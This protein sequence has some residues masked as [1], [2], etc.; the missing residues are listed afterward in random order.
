VGDD[1]EFFAAVTVYFTLPIPLDCEKDGVSFER[2][3]EFS[4][5]A[6]RIARNWS[7]TEPQPMTYAVVVLAS[8]SC[9][10]VV[11]CEVTGT[12]ASGRLS[13]R[14]V[15]TMLCRWGSVSPNC[16]QTRI[17]HMRI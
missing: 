14:C 13:G 3:V 2:C 16:W 8:A 7:Y 10:S 17:T 15:S 12:G 1:I 11:D 4:Q 6:H 5:N 9:W